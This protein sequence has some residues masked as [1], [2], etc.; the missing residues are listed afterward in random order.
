MIKHTI[1]ALLIGLLIFG[2]YLAQY[3]GAFKKVNI[4]LES[5][6]TFYLIGKN[7]NGAYHQIVPVIQEVESW[8]KSNSLDCRLSFGEYIDNPNTTEEG[9]LRSIGGCIISSSDH[10]KID[11]WKEKI[12]NEYFLKEIQA[13]KF[14]VAKFEGSPGFGPIKV[15]PKVQNFSHENQI[16]LLGPNF[17]IYEIFEK[18]KMITTYLFYL[19]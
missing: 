3:V 2:L 16:A 10:K 6:E 17:E 12:P 4:G 11:E 13:Q 9:R 7:H 14:L 5:R 18:N 19:K 15:Y 8:F 1:I